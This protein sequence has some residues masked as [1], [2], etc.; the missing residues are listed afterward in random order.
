MLN[1]QLDA[2]EYTALTEQQVKLA[3]M[4]IID[5]ASE[6]IDELNAHGNGLRR[7]EARGSLSTSLLALERN[8]VHEH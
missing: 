2:I 6:A 7:E 1:H 5:A 8:T 3:M 4:T